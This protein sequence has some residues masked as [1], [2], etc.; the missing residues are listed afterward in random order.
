MTLQKLVKRHSLTD[1][2]LNCE[3]GKVDIPFLAKHFD[4]IELYMEVMNLCSAEQGDV[5][6]TMHA[7]GNQVAMTKCLSLWKGQISYNA[8][9]RALLEVLLRLE[10]G[11]VANNVCLYLAAKKGKAIL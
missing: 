2:Q 5:V 1:I 8:T 3:I 4:K 10:K 11:E 9:Y 7:S 6:K